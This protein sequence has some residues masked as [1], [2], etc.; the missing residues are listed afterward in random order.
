MYLIYI[1]CKHVMHKKPRNL[2][3][4]ALGTD[5]NIVSKSISPDLQPLGVVIHDVSNTSIVHSVKGE[6][7]DG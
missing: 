3:F 6:L 5:S 4:W 1:Y 7:Q 2:D